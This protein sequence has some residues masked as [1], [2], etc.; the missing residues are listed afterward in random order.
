MNNTV[1]IVELIES[2]PIT[3]LSNTY[4][5]KLLEKIKEN[6]IDEEQHL[7]ITSF[8]CFLNYNPRTDF[9]IDL[10]NVWGWLGFYQKVKAKTL[11]EKHFLLDVEYKILVSQTGKQEKHGGHNKETFLLS[12]RTF[13]LFCLKAGTK[14]AEQI[15]EYY[16]KLEETLH[17]IL[18]EESDELKTQL[19]KKNIEMEEQLLNIQRD[20]ELLREKTILE[21]FPNNVQCVYYGLIDNVSSNNEKL[22]KFGN[23]NN[24]KERVA[25]HKETYLNFRL[26]SA[27]KVDN[28]L[29]IEN[30]IKKHNLFIDRNR[31]LT[32]KNKRYIEI[33]SIEHLEFDVI[34][35]TI[36]EIITSIEYSPSNYVKILDENIKLKKMLESKKQPDNEAE[37]FIL[38]TENA[39]LK[40]EHIK[41]MS[42]YNKL[43]QKIKQPD[44]VIINDVENEE[45][46]EKKIIENYGSII[47]TLKNQHKR[48]DKNKD[49]KYEIFGKIY[50]KL[51]GT[52][53]EV[54]NEIAYKTAGC[55]I[56]S[57]LLMNKKGLIVSKKKFIQETNNNKFVLLGIIKPK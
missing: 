23:S 35:K 46:N 49:G 32:I 31:D 18:E 52:R 57:E 38:K 10:D 43:K 25:K 30:A 51:I 50:D 42:K 53:E 36:K 12:I 20:K 16:I 26:V 28:K 9:I 47:T 24:L 37:I 34:D 6:F 3:K 44:N 17:E 56:K 14:K 41:L 19:E 40:T 13:K 15:H 29:Q 45:N 21:H 5:N 55:L 4:Q 11:L 48:V 2:N 39:N 33:L 1:D 22:I 54:W 8:Y 27:F 7:F